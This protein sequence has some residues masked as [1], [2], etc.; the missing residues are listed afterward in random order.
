MSWRPVGFTF[1]G[2]DF[3]FKKVSKK[4]QPVAV[5]Q[6]GSETYPTYYCR[7]SDKG[8]E[9]VCF[10]T[11]ADAFNVPPTNASYFDAAPPGA[12]FL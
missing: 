2:V 6:N 9:W 8:N 12:L 1:L 3:G 4:L 5:S 11:V 7:L 10:P